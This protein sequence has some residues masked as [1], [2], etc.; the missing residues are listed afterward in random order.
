[1]IQPALLPPYTRLFGPVTAGRVVRLILIYLAMAA[2]GLALAKL[3]PDDHWQAFGL[4]L[5]LPGG[6]F[7]AHYDL[8]SAF[9]LWHVA[10]ALSAAG[11]FALGLGVWFGTGNILAPPAVW[12]GAAVWAASMNHGHTHPVGVMTVVVILLI[13]IILLCITTAVRFVMAHRAR[14]ADNV[15][16]SGPHV[17]F[18]ARERDDEMSLDHLQRLRFAYD[19]ALQRVED[20]AG[21][22]HLDPFQTAAIRY[23]VNFLA[24]AL[25]LSHA[26]F[27]PAF[28]GYGRQAQINLID[29]MAQPSVWSYWRLENLWG[30]LDADPNPLGRDN[31]MYT[32]FLGLQM[33]LLARSTG[34]ADFEHGKRFRLNDRLAFDAGDVYGRLIS[35]YERS[36][37]CLFPCEPN[38]IYPLCNTIG[39]GALLGTHAHAWDD[40]RDRFMAQADAEFLDAFG[41][42]VP[43][44]SSRTGVA[45]PAIGGAMPLA[46]PCFFLNALA[47]EIAA[48]QWWLLRRRLFR[49]SCFDRGAFWPID[50]GNYGF[51]RASA[52]TAAMLAAAELGDGQVYDACLAALDD[53]CPSTEDRG[54][55]HRQRA[56]VWSHGVELMARAGHENGFRDLM[57]RPRDHAG[58]R[59]EGLTYPEVLVASAHVVD[60][61]LSAILYGGKGDGVFDIS[62]SGLKSHTNYTLH[63]AASGH[64]MAGEDGGIDFTI[65]LKGRTVLRLQ[66]E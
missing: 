6:G 7:L 25:A 57:A 23:Q 14:H 50:T 54:V 53:E 33:A 36:P 61:G 8:V 18:P 1:M 47:P 20:F 41:R 45:L 42:F 13:F 12:L 31:I 17:A 58:P 35:E 22:E 38:W 11:L 37:F 59:L 44:R 40:M 62:V 34:A 65:T 32:G 51:S 21:F 9:G 15:F 19:R 16:L 3:A 24:Y 56:S 30:N 26:R 49:N 43:C 66:P 46:M 60:G 5:V 10:A 63:G 2:T 29:K 28:G 27:T 52:Y 4:G 39:A 64:I 48:R 55:I